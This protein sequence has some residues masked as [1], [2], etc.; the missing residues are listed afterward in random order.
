MRALTVIAT[1]LRQKPV[2]AITIVQNPRS[3]PWLK[4]SVNS[5]AP[6][7]ISGVVRGSTMRRLMSAP[8]W[9]R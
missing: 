7:T 5:E 3:T 2:W 1:K 4:N 6:I 8:P 9:M